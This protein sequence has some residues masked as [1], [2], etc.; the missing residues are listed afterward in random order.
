MEVLED[1]WRQI[2]HH[3]AVLSD[4][5]AFPIWTENGRWKT[6]RFDQEEQGVLPHHGSWM[7]G[8]L[9][10]ILWFVSTDRTHPQAAPD[11]VD[12]ALRWSNRLQ[13]RTGLKSFASVAHMFFRGAL[14]GL[15]LGGDAR[16]Q[17]LAEAAARTASDRFLEIG[18][19][20]SFGSPSDHSFPFTTIDDVINLAVPLWLSKRTADAALGQAAHAAI[21]LIAERLVRPDGSVA[22]VLTF[23]DDGQPAK[24][25]TYQGFSPDGCWSRGQAWG[26]YGLAAAYRVCAEPHFLQL[27]QEMCDYWI[28]RVQDDPAPLWDFDLPAAEPPIRDTFA[29]TLAYAGILEVASHSGAA[30]CAELRGYVA[31]MLGRL[32]QRYVVGRAAGSGIVAGAALDV[33]H[34]H[35]INESVIVGDSYF[36]EAVWRLVVADQPATDTGLFPRVAGR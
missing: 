17:P 13:N 14:V 9:P 33:P 11:A 20:K 6:V 2:H 30:R 8:D 10:A 26:I 16:L 7:V 28:S 5:P 1:A 3:A 18:Y 27:A 23:D 12:R 19:M 21:E 35:G 34:E 4:L 36:V 24:V 22:Q 31:E 29:A 32:A 25:D 15:A